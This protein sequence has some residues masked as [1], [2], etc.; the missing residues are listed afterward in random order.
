MDAKFLF[1][2]I[3][4]SLVIHGI[5]MFCF[6]YLGREIEYRKLVKSC[7]EGY[8]KRLKEWKDGPKNYKNGVPIPKPVRLGIDKF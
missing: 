2:L 3:F 4:I 5:V 8:E 1:L 7:D 6:I